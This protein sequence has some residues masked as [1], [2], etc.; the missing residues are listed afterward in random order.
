MTLSEDK[1]ALRSQ[2]LTKRRELPLDTILAGSRAI[3]ERIQTWPRF[4]HARTVMG[5]L[6][7]SGEPVLD[8]LLSTAIAAG[9]TVCV[10]L[11]GSVYGHMEA[12]AID[13][14]DHLISGRIGVRMPDPTHAKI[15]FPE[16][17]DLIL[18]PGVVFDVKGNR[19]GMGAGYYDRFLVR[20]PQAARV[21]IAWN[22]QVYDC[23]PRAEH[24]ILMQWLVTEDQIIPCGTNGQSAV[25]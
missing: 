8:E 23:I 17:I 12:A 14:F 25:W 6:A 20:A 22:M 16:A 11:M 2:V 10:P 3:T 13:S 7:M 4:L 18:T 21:G 19:I 5:Y 24:D 1:S 15:V 9:K